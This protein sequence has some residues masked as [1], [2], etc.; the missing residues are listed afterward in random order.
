[1]MKK[2]GPLVRVV[3]S[4]LFIGI[5]L[6][7]MRGNYR[8][9]FELIKH[10]RISTFAYSVFV[11]FL[12][13][14]IAS[15]RLKIL[16]EA[17][18]LRL[19]FMESVNLT[20]I[21]YFFNNFLPT[22][23]GGDVVKAYYVAKKTNNMAASFASVFM[24]RFLGL[25]TMMLM[26]VLALLLVKGFVKDQRA[27]NMLYVVVALSGIF[28][29]FIFNRG[30]A[31]RFSFFLKLAGP[32]EHKLRELYNTVHSYQR[33]RLLLA[34]SVLLS[35]FSQFAYF[36][37]IFLIALSMGSRVPFKELFLRVPL[38][39]ALTLLPSINGL[40]VR[41][42]SVVLLFGPLMG[43]G[44]A[45]AMSLLMLATL[46]IASLI[47]GLI[48]AFSPQFKIEMKAPQVGL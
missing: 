29:A 43:K 25:F 44:N 26:A 23:I 6:Y 31:S 33:H 40:G 5:L 15:M 8:A 14:A 47:G 37:S 13:L 24:D 12:A 4:L 32:I 48:Y 16:F 41:E 20:L 22:A 27:V 19:S 21:G 18:E 35:F 39:S 42:G 2:M 36:Y 9:I 38:V 45:F 30:F 11:F 17:Q 10:T 7:T 28:L 1:M 3:V 34:Q 46:I